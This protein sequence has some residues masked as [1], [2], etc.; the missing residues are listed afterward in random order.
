MVRAHVGFQSQQ[1]CER[2]AILGID[3]SVAR[4]PSSTRIE[5]VKTL[6]SDDANARQ[7]AVISPSR[8]DHFA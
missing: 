2:R 7:L 5:L 6:R 8:F 4:T 1:R 3:G